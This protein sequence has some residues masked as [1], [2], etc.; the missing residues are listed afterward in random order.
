M[1]IN[2]LDD[3]NDR[4]PNVDWHAQNR[5]RPVTGQ[6]VDRP[7]E[8]LVRV[9]IRDI[10]YFAGH[11]DLTGDPRS[12]REANLARSVRLD[13]LL[14]F[15]F[16]IVAGRLVLDA[17]VEYSRVQLFILGIDQEKGCPVS[18]DQPLSEVHYLHY[19]HVHA[20]HVLKN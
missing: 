3:A 18:V 16:G 9:G 8:S 1:F 11:G 15:R 20:D 19:E 17:Y 6:L 7:V 14:V 4:S 10:Q 13:G 2:H 5:L 12:E